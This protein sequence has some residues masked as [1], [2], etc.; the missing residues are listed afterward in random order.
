[1]ITNDVKPE[2]IKTSYIGTKFAENA[3][4][5]NRT[6]KTSPFTIAFMGYAR[7]DKGFWFL[8]KCLKNIPEDIAKN[9]KV[10]LAA[11]GYKKQ[12]KI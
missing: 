1:M 4:N 9:I 11:K 8:I 6:D 10:V 12:M 3:M 7:I 2:I 5:K